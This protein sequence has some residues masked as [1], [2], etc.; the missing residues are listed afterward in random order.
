MLVYSLAVSLSNIPCP[1][2]ILFL[3]TTVTTA[4]NTLLV[5]DKVFRRFYKLPV[6][7][8]AI[9][10]TIK[11]RYVC[12]V[13]LKVFQVVI[14]VALHRPSQSNFECLDILDNKMLPVIMDGDFNINF[15]LPSPMGH[16]VKD[17]CSAYNSA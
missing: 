7:Y 2:S 8:P 1:H 3:S 5:I 6:L 4:S 11:L 17:L 14:L 16:R 12:P 13:E 10:A 9:T 15:L